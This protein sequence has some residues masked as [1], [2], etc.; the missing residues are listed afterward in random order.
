MLRQRIARLT[1]SFLV[2]MSLMVTGS[3]TALAKAPSVESTEYKGKG[4]VEIDFH[5]KVRYKRLKITVKDTK[6]KKYK[7]KN[8]RRDDD[9]LN[10]TIRNFKKGRTYRITVKG[11]KRRGTAAYGK[12]TRKVKIPAAAKAGAAISR[13]KALQIAKNHASKTWNA[14]GFWDVDV[15][16]DRYG[17][18]SVWEVSFNGTRNG[19]PYEFEYEIAVNGGRIIYRHCEY[20]D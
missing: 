9:D 19:R 11:V 8:I 12:F 15:E 10:F 1:V 13:D 17:S 3:V 7:V 18:Q 16:R 5:G 4:R 20:D 6:G 14:S 2:T